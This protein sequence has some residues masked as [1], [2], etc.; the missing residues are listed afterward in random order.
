MEDDGHLETPRMSI[1]F[2]SR[3][4]GFLFG[5]GLWFPLQR[6][7]ATLPLRGKG[8]LDIEPVIAR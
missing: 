8:V 3:L 4:G 7:L 2:W 5:W 6:S 1:G